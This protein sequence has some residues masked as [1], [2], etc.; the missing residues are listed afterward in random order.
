MA[1]LSFMIMVYGE[2]TFT[3]RLRGEDEIEVQGYGKPWVTS[4]VTN[5]IELQSHG[6]A[7][8]TLMVMGQVEIEVQSYGEVWVMSM[9]MLSYEGEGDI[10]DQAYGKAWTTS[11]MMIQGPGQAL[12]LGIRLRMRLRFRVTVKLH[13]VDGDA[14]MVTIRV[15]FP[16]CCES[17]NDIEVQSFCEAWVMSILMATPVA[18]GGRQRIVLQETIAGCWWA[19]QIQ[20]EGYHRVSPLTNKVQIPPRDADCH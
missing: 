18:V 15:R 12:G 13:E 20:G 14:L 7:W 17:E 1:K 2:D 5:E 16:L 4:M 10:G 11:M 8:V 6:E 9:L 19:V 3:D